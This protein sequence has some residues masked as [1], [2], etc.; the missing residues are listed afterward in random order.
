MVLSVDPRGY[1]V[2][3]PL[4]V[5]TVATTEI[6]TKKTLAQH[7]TLCD[8]T[9]ATVLASPKDHLSDLVFAANWGLWLPR[10]PEKVVLLSNMK[11]ESRARETVWVEKKLQ[12]MKVKTIRF[13]KTQ[14][15][16]GQGESCW[17][18][19]GEL[20]VVGY[21]YRANSKSVQVLQHKLNQVYSA[22]GVEPPYVVGV[23][24]TDPK[25]YHLDLAMCAV[26]HTSCLLRSGSITA[27]SVQRVKKYLQLHILNTS[28]DFVFNL[29]VLP[30][31][32]VSHKLK[33]VRDKKFI[34]KHGQRPLVEVDVSEFEKAGGSV[35]CM[36][37]VLFCPHNGVS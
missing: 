12:N 3:E 29:L 15:F 2:E 6:D 8:S 31:K 5:F 28:D 34:E 22:Y 24:L 25:F 19:N 1:T 20:L 4:N 13:P 36:S 14:P 37:L 23:K 10:L 32:I 33:H 17:F 9:A 7:A 26:S 30:D 27:A 35:G 11:Y 18:H 21:G 16:E